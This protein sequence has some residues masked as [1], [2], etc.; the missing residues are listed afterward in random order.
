MSFSCAQ[1]PLAG[2][3]VSSSLAQRGDLFTPRATST[4]GQP[5]TM[6]A[7]VPR[8]FELNMLSRWMTGRDSGK[9]RSRNRRDA[10]QRVTPAGYHYRRV[11][12][13][14]T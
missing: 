13:C 5:I 2:A 9:A 14:V 1:V 4:A 12:L 8:N 11:R 3:G 7:S 6:D 10:N